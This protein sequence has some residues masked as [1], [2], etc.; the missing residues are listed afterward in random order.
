[1]IEFDKRLE[2]RISRLQNQIDKQ[3]KIIDEATKKRKDLMEELKKD[4]NDFDIDSYRKFIDAAKQKNKNLKGKELQNFLNDCIGSLED[5]T[6]IAKSI[7]E[8]KITYAELG[9]NEISENDEKIIDKEIS[10]DEV[11]DI[12]SRIGKE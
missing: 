11:E 4:Q 7:E 12:L 3:N 1:M 2:K 8:E 6:E 9:K 10:D 5:N